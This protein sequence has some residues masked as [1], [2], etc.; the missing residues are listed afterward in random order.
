MQDYNAEAFS[1][2]QIESEHDRQRAIVRDR[3][4]KLLSA[5][6]LDS[7]IIRELAHRDIYQIAD[8]SVAATAPDDGTSVPAIFTALRAFLKREGMAASG[9]VILLS[10]LGEGPVAPP[11]SEYHLFAPSGRA[12][13]G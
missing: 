7:S 1:K 2:R 8:A 3:L 9:I 13:S 12:A 11:L 5:R 6:A 10:F 4:D